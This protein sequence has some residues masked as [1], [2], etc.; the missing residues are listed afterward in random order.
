MGIL[1]GLPFCW[2]ILL[3]EY[4]EGVT[5]LLVDYLWVDVKNMHLL[6]LQ[7]TNHITYGVVIVKGASS[8][9]D[10]KRHAL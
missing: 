10:I 1:M 2:H 6:I 3:L 4:F 8:S 7:K 5:I 9:I